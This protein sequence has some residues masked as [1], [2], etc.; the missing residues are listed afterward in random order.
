M[1]RVEPTGCGMASV[2]V[3]A[4][5]GRLLLKRAIEAA[6]ERRW[7]RLEHGMLRLPEFQ[8]SMDCYQRNA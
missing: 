1:V 4:S 5:V 3:I 8:G 7:T 2:A 6:C